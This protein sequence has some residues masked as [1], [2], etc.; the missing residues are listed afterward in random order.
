MHLTEKAQATGFFDT[1]AA[2][3]QKV[4]S[5]LLCQPAH[6]FARWSEQV[7]PR[8]P[9]PHPARPPNFSQ[10]WKLPSLED[11]LPKVEDFMAYLFHNSNCLSF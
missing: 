4:L 2:R 5:A 11:L 8:R 1:V 10:T 7:A 9:P 3:R 6:T